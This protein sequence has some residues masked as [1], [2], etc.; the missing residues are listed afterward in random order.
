MEDTV[1]APDHSLALVVERVCKSQAGSKLLAVSRD[2]A[3]GRIIRIGHGGLRQ[4]RVIVPYTEVQGQALRDLILV[5]QIEAVIL[6][7]QIHDR[8]ANGLSEGQPILVSSRVPAQVHRQS[9]ETGEGIG[10][11]PVKQKIGVV[12]RSNEFG[13]EF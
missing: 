9:R 13:A 5:L 6:D 7:E 12:F 4:V 11:G 8:I 10:S 2:A 3:A 1:T